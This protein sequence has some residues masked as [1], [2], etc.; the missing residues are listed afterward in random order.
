VTNTR[1]GPLTANRAG[2]PIRV[3][4]YDSPDN[5]A[6]DGTADV[7]IG[8][9][10]P[11]YFEVLQIPLVRG[12][13]FLPTDDSA[14][15][16]VAVVNE[17]FV[18]RF[19][20]GTDPIGR[21]FHDDSATVTV[22]GVVRDAKYG[23]LSGDTPPFVYW[24]VTQRASRTLNILVR[25]RGPDAALTVL[26]RNAVHT[27]D[28]LL[29]VPPVLT[30]EA[31]TSVVLLPQRVAAAVTAVM[32]LLGLLLSAVGLYGVVAFTAS[33][34]TREIGVRMALGA[35]RR[36]VLGLV[37]H[38]GMRLVGIGMGIGLVLAV[39]LTRAMTHFLFGVSPLDP[40][41]FVLVPLALAGVALLANY[42]P[43]RRAASTDPLE[44]L[45]AE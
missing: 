42:L 11:D 23:K 39:L 36:N 28:P 37:M 29:P 24:P 2:T 30:M 21:T 35:N 3:D 9:V 14:A 34:R 31:A 41:V 1:W 43:A 18:R 38:D 25:S 40:L 26:I 12:R 33:Q 6:H 44:A 32:G 27:I 16:R 5:P 20:P 15:V 22:V 8:I 19:W 45:R 13:A 10:A 4:G 17:T 7:E